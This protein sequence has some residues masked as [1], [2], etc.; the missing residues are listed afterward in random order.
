MSMYMCYINAHRDGADAIIQLLIGILYEISL[1]IV[2]V[3]MM[4]YVVAGRMLATSWVQIIRAIILM[5]A[6]AIMSVFLGVIFNFNSSSSFG[7]IIEGSTYKGEAIGSQ[8]IEFLERG[9]LY[10]NPIDLLSVGITLILGTAGLSHL[11]V[12]F[13]TVPTAQAARSSVVWGMIIIGAFYLL[14]GIIGFAAA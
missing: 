4:I 3:L 7:S 9:R 11:L 1:I 13:F 12:R 5:S 14:I 10:K 2:V 6:M 8:G